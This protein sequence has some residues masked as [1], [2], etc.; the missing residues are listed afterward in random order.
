MMDCFACR[1]WWQGVQSIIWH[2]GMQFSCV[3]AYGFVHCCSNAWLW[4]SRSYEC[5][6]CDNSFSSS[7][8]I[9][10]CSSIYGLVLHIY[11]IYYLYYYLAHVIEIRCMLCA[12]CF[13]SSFLS[14]KTVLNCAYISMVVDLF[15]VFIGYSLQWSQCPRKSPCSICVAS[16][17]FW[18]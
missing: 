5:F 16:V 2:C 10:W 12:L 15:V 7:K 1:L 17:S 14:C 4:P 6:S 8:L 9:T 11:I 13:Q 18:S 3:G